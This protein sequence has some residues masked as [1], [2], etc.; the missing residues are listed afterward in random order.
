MLKVIGVTRKSGVY[1]GNNFDNFTLQCVEDAPVTSGFVAGATVSTVKIKASTLRDV[2]DGL[3]SAPADW[4]L[5]IG[6]NIRVFC[7]Q[8]GRPVKIEI[9]DREGVK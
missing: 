7:D 9:I 6:Q 5:V 4:D 3:V 1:E 8:Y 2:F